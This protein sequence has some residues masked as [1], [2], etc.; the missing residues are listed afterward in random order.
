MVT[1][2][3]IDLETLESWGPIIN[4]DPFT[5]HPSVVLAG[6]S[7]DLPESFIET[8]LRD[9]N[10][11]PGIDLQ[12]SFVGIRRLDRRNPTTSKIEPS[13][14][15]RLFLTDPTAT[16][17][18][19][20]HGS[21]SIGGLLALVRPYRTPQYFCFNCRTQ[22]SHKTRDCRR[23]NTSSPSSIHRTNLPTRSVPTEILSTE[24]DLMD[25]ES[26]HQSQ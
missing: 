21:V 10:R 26:V 13:R 18:L 1:P 19:L 24:Q 2:F 5:G 11:I 14:S 25:T 16:E 22:G 3:R 12:A 15:L 23:P 8:E 4:K 7:Q 6:I 17:A 20:K 9:Y